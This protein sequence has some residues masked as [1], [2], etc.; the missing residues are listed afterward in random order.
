MYLGSIRQPQSESFYNLSII[1][2]YS[3]PYHGKIFS[4]WID[5]LKSY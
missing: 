5:S 3:E 2:S 4:A 1:Q